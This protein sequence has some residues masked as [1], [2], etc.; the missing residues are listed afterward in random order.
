MKNYSLKQALPTSAIWHH[1]SDMW[2]QMG[3]ATNTGG[4]LG[5]NPPGGVVT[6]LT[7]SIIIMTSHYIATG[8]S[9][10]IYMAEAAKK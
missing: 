2:H 8:R 10:P 1:V 9:I 4:G 7:P 6:S 5:P 3:L